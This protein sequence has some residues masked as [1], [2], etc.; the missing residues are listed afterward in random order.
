MKSYIVLLSCH[1][2]S[3]SCPACSAGFHNGAHHLD[4]QKDNVHTMLKFLPYLALFMDENIFFYET[5]FPIGIS[6]SFD[7]GCLIRFRTCTDLYHVYSSMFYVTLSLNSK[8]PAL[9]KNVDNISRV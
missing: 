5:Y 4:P 1:L 8:Y 7:P 9:L 3:T 6:N 2:T